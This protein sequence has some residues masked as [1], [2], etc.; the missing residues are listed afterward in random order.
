M[1]QFVISDCCSDSISTVINEA[2]DIEEDKIAST[3]TGEMKALKR[4]F[5]FG[6]KL[7]VKKLH[8]SSKK[9]KYAKKFKQKEIV[10]GDC[11]KEDAKSDSTEQNEETG[12]FGGIIEEHKKSGKIRKKVDIFHAVLHIKFYF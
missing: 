4:F 3:K 7:L 9:F 2:N 6:K 10:I 1:I 11:N 12:R 5:G 8:R